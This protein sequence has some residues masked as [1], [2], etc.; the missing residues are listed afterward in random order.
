MSQVANSYNLW[1]C[2]T[3]ITPLHSARLP[4]TFAPSQFQAVCNFPLS[5]WCVALGIQPRSYFC[6]LTMLRM[7]SIS[8]QWEQHPAFPRAPNPSRQL[9][10][11]TRNQ[12]SEKYGSAFSVCWKSYR[13]LRLANNGNSVRRSQELPIPRVNSIKRP[14][15]RSQRSTVSPSPHVCASATGSR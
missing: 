10:K 14:E 12:I 1:E 4:W 3:V 9:Y 7:P 11:K 6:A 5:P 15:I 2:R 13:C 8:R